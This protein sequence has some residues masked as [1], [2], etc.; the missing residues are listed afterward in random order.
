M[1]FRVRKR[2]AIG[3]NWQNLRAFKVMDFKV[4]IYE[5]A[6]RRAQSFNVA[7]KLA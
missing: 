6:R 2:Q 7:H 3:N 4:P 5:K 1:S